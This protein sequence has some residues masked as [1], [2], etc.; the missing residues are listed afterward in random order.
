MT[1]SV[2]LMLM[3]LLLLLLYVA[4]IRNV[5]ERHMDQKAERRGNRPTVSVGNIVNLV[6]IFHS[7]DDSADE[8]FGSLGGIVDGDE[9]E[10]AEGLGG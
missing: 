1:P 9:L 3:L 10:W 6:P 7:L 5:L 4:Y 2:L 8:S